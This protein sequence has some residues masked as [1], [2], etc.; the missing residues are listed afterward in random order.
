MAATVHDLPSVDEVVGISQ[1]ILGLSLSWLDGRLNYINL[2][3]NT[4]LNVLSPTEFAS[5]WAPVL[6]FFNK[7]PNF[8]ELEEVVS[9][10]ISVIANVS[11]PSPLSLFYSTNVFSGTSNT[12]VWREQIRKLK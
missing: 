11:S 3:N 6:Q 1:V 4:D 9:P 8:K 5:I 2:V 7:A 10:T 12:L